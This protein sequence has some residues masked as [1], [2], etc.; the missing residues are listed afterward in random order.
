MS[1]YWTESVNQ[2]SDCHTYERKTFLCEISLTSKVKCHDS[3]DWTLYYLNSVFD[4]IDKIFLVAVQ[5]IITSSSPVLDSLM[6]QWCW[7]PISVKVKLRSQTTCSSL[8]DNCRRSWE[9]LPCWTISHFFLLIGRNRY[10]R[11]IMNDSHVNKSVVLIAWVVGIKWATLGQIWACLHSLS[12]VSLMHYTQ[13]N[14]Y[15]MLCITAY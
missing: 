4:S 15:L 5:K 2:K 3:P 7:I 8:P 14:T 10:A 11:S 13:K 9:G 6:S 1:F 12:L